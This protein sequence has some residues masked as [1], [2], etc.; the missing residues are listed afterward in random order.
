MW[1]LGQYAAA[2]HLLL[3]ADRHSWIADGHG[4]S[5][6]LEYDLNGN[7]ALSLGN[8]GTTARGTLESAHEITTDQTGNLFVA[9]VFNGR[10]QNFQPREGADAANL[11]GQQMR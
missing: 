11:V 8:L 6:I 4:T 1:D 2:Y 3:T 9:E 10:A 7:A 5:K